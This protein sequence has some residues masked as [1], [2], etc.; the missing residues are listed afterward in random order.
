MYI[1]REKAKETVQVWGQRLRDYSKEHLRENTEQRKSKE[2][3][4]FFFFI[5]SYLHTMFGPFLLPIPPSL[6]PHL[7][8]SPPHPLT[9]GRNYSAFC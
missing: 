5:Y 6:S 7:L 4:L 9:Q 8:P 2:R 3:G 1:Y